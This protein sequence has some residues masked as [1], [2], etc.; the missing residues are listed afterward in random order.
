MDLPG[1][2]AQSEILKKSMHPTNEIDFLLILEPHGWSTCWIFAEGKPIELT[3]THIFNDPYDELISALCRLMKGENLVTLFWYA[4]PGGERIEIERLKD[5]KKMLNIRF[6]GFHECFGDE[7]KDV[8]PTIHFEM[9]ER[10]FL[11][12]AYYQLKKT[13]QLLADVS[14]AK[15]RNGDFPFQRF[16]IFEA[17]VRNYLKIDV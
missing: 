10:Q 16:K 9:T 4:E 6:D 3:I 8:E 5:K 15:S 13:E 17:E 14:F 2:V 7:V 11:I 1:L 12:T